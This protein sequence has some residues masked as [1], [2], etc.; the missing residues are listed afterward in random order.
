MN[1]FWMTVILLVTGAS[2]VKIDVSVMEGDS[3]TLHTD[4]TKTPDNKVQWY[5]NDIRIARITGD[6]SKTCTDVQC[7]NHSERFRDRLHLDH[8]TGS[9]TIRDLTKTDSGEYKLQII[10]TGS[11]SEKIFNVTIHDVSAADQE[12]MKRKSVKEGESVTLDPGVIKKTDGLMKWYFNDIPINEI[13]GN[14]RRSCTDVQCKDGVERFRDRLK[15]NQTG[16][17]NITNIK[18]TDSGEYQLQIISSRFSIK[19]S[20]SVNVSA[21]PDS[22]LSPAVVAGISAALVLLTV[23]AAAVVYYRRRPKHGHRKKPDEQKNA[24]DVTSHNEEEPLMDTTN[25]TSPNHNDPQSK[26]TDNVTSP[27]LNDP[28]SKYTTDMTSPNHN[29]P[30]SKD[31]SDVTSPNHNDPQSKDTDNVTSPNHNDPQSKDTS[32]VTSPNHNDPQ[33]KDTDNVTSPNHNDPQSKDTSDVTS[34]NHNDPQSKDTD[35][36]TSPNHNDPQLKDTTEVINKK[37]GLD[38]I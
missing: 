15:V 18:T 31:T 23:T 20:F 22:G 14:P 3:V 6:P 2:A 9:L 11:S 38:L 25:G 37:G 7:N 19:R 36:V 17:L 10:I 16:S 12:E 32:D 4:V 34:P 26:D 30:Q 27:N 5:Y 33:S 35:N 21:V 1:Y 13:P 28:Q 24:T 29:D 8:Q